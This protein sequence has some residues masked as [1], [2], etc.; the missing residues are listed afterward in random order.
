MQNVT[1]TAS[2]T[3]TARCSST[4]EFRVVARWYTVYIYSVPH[5]KRLMLLRSV[6]NETVTTESME[7]AKRMLRK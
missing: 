7:A 1:S 3:I 6:W 2:D 5:G 4:R